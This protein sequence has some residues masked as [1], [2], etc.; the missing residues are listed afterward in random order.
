MDRTDLKLQEVGDRI[1]NVY[2]HNE[3]ISDLIAM[4]ETKGKR[5]RLSATSV[6]EI[7]VEG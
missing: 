3:A 5:L 2:L 1:K 6:R 4:I 7:G